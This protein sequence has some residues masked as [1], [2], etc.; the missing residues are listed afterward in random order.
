MGKFVVWMLARTPNSHP[1]PA[2][3]PDVGGDIPA[4]PTLELKINGETQ[5]LSCLPRPRSP[6]FK[7]GRRWQ[8]G[9]SSAGRVCHHMLEKGATSW[10]P[11]SPSSSEQKRRWKF[12]C[13]Q[14]YQLVH[15]YQWQL[16]LEHFLLIS[17]LK[18]QIWN[19]G[20]SFLFDHVVPQWPA[21]PLR[22]NHFYFYNRNLS[23]NRIFPNNR[24]KSI[25]QTFIS[26]RHFSINNR[27]ISIKHSSSRTE[28]K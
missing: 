14:I 26:I 4:V 18:I 2:H 15:S 13:T 28:Y 12:L 23:N 7:E 1:T 19:T 27:N 11:K 17:F 24:R 20:I 6:W 5:N 8:Q 9:S 3:L 25:N 10:F 21:G 22:S 16:G